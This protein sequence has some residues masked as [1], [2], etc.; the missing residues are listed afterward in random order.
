MVT[1]LVVSQSSSENGSDPMK[2]ITSQIFI[3]IGTQNLSKAVLKN[4]E[5]DARG[6]FYFNNLEF[7]NQSVFFFFF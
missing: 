1:S 7:I 6:L 5:Y 3:E 4:E 2:P